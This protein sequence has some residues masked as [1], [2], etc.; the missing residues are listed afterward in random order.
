MARSA[1]PLIKARLESVFYAP[2]EQGFGAIHLRRELFKADE[3]RAEQMVSVSAS[4]NIVVYKWDNQHGAPNT[5]PSQT[6]RARNIDDSRTAKVNLS[7]VG[8]IFRR[9]TNC[10][11]GKADA[12]TNFHDNPL[13]FHAFR[14]LASFHPASTQLPHARRAGVR[15]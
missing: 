11:R 4:S 6:L 15:T 5:P 13:S 1:P 12:S 8:S 14:G 2:A 7:A 3:L 9:L 10:F